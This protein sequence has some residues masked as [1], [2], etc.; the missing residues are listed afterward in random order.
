MQAPTTQGLRQ[1]R[2]RRE[3]LHQDDPPRLDS[4]QPML[5]VPYEKTFHAATV[6]ALEPSSSI[7]VSRSRQRGLQ[8]RVGT[9]W[10][11][12]GTTRRKRSC[13][14]TRLHWRER[15][16]LHRRITP[17]SGSR[18]QHRIRTRFLHRSTPPSVA[19]SRRWRS[20]VRI[21][22]T[23][24]ALVGAQRGFDP[25]Q[26]TRHVVGD[27]RVRVLD[28][29]QW[30]EMGSAEMLDVATAFDELIRPGAEVGRR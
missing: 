7:F 14:L 4:T 13:P 2:M 15:S 1:D 10:P 3:P 12:G 28:L 18:R 27:G 6:I 20:G 9:R 30:L 8:T 29:R 22:S 16:R 24:A 26:S 11:A 5:R 19:R 17:S 21:E 25:R 23:V